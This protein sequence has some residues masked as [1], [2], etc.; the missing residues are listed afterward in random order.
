MP[1][2]YLAVIKCAYARIFGKSLRGLQYLRQVCNEAKSSIVLWLW[3]GVVGV[4][5]VYELFGFSEAI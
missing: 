4:D 2:R 3:P 5:P 1:F